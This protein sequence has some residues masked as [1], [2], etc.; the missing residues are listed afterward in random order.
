MSETIR[1]KAILIDAVNRR[2]MPFEYTGLESL[3]KAVGGWIEGC[4]DVSEKGDYLFCNE[5]GLLNGTRDFFYAP[6]L[7]PS[8]IAGNAV[9]T[10]PEIDEIT[11]DVSLSVA[12]VA[13]KVRFFDARGAYAVAKELGI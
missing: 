4:G 12:D 1:K 11:Q 13:G 2:V 7:Y 9:I 10:G 5:E 3:Q 6:D 8:P